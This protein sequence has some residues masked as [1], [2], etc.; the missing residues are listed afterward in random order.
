MRESV[1]LTVKEPPSSNQYWRQHGRVTY[2]TREAKEYIEMVANAALAFKKNGGP[3]FPE[4][5]VT[6][7]LVWHRSRRSG[8][9]D[10]RS[11][12][13]YDAL[14]GTIYADDKQIAQDWRRRCDAHPEIPKGHVRV[15]VSALR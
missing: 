1:T 7:V 14:Q 11:K 13:L 15:E 2:R 10:N 5:D 4:G 8:D 6:I 3:C 9:L 12:V